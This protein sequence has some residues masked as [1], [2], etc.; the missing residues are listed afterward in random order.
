LDIAA[1]NVLRSI[2]ENQSEKDLSMA[3]LRL[4]ISI[5]LCMIF[6]SGSAVWADEFSELKAR[7]KSGDAVAQYDLGVFY[8]NKEGKTRTR[9]KYQKQAVDW[10]TKAAKQGLASAQFNL[11]RMYVA[12]KGITRDVELGISWQLK[13]AE[14]GL[15]GAQFAIGKRYFSGVGLTQDYQQALDMFLRAAEQGFADAQNQL[16]VMHFQGEGVP[17]DNVQAHKWFNIAST[18]DDASAKRLKSVLEQVM[19]SEQIE[20]AQELAAQWLAERS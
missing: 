5:F 3:T 9:I 19:D 6:C 7:A 16:G 18:S 14:Q 13:A 11:G 10:Y 1:R 4:P 8:D 2:S 17:K 12:G 15:A 20:E